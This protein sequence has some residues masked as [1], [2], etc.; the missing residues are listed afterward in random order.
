MSKGSSTSQ[1]HNSSTSFDHKRVERLRRERPST[2]KHTSTRTYQQEHAGEYDYRKD[3][4]ILRDL[5]KQLRKKHPGIS[6]LR[7]AGYPLYSPHVK[8]YRLKKNQRFPG[9]RND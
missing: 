4:L 1:L 3:P 5:L 8:I 7:F 2:R 9:G 6:I